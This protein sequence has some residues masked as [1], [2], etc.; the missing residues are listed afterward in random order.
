[1]RKSRISNKDPSKLKQLRMYSLLS[2][3]SFSGL[4]SSPYSDFVCLVLPMGSVVT[5]LQ[6]VPDEP[7]P[8]KE[9]SSQVSTLFS[10]LLSPDW[11]FVP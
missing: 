3:S 4:F 10:L 5:Q 9:D 7:I 6:V 11:F 2:F 1:M 8:E